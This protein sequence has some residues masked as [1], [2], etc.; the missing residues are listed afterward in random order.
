VSIITAWNAH[1]DQINKLGSLR[2]ARETNPNL[3]TFYSKDQWAKDDDSNRSRR[4]I[5][6]YKRKPI[7]KSN[8]LNPGL[9]K[10]LWSLPHGST[11]HIPGKLS[12]CVG[13]PVMLHYNEA[14]ERCMT[15]GTEATVAGWQASIGPHE[16]PILDTLFVKLSNPPK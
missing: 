6:N 10:E 14:T 12:I 7:R 3:T 4:K 8:T 9:Q 13:M 1:K 11:E 16:K 5:N 15:K 2:F